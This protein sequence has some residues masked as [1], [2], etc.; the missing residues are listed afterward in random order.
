MTC[1]CTKNCTIEEHER[2]YASHEPAPDC[3]VNCDRDCRALLD[4]KTLAEA[5]KALGHWRRH[6][7]LSGCSHGN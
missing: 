3:V 6:G 2:G 4:P 7:Y 1:D 5:L